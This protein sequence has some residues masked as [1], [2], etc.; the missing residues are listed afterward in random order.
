MLESLIL[1]LD[2]SPIVFDYNSVTIHIRTGSYTC[3]Y[4]KDS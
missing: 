4:Y 3:F 2:Q 1:I